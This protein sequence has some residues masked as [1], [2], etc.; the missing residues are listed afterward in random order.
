[1]VPFA[2]LPLGADARNLVARGWRG[3]VRTGPAKRQMM[4]EETTLPAPDAPGHFRDNWPYFW[5]NRANAWYTMALEKRLKPIGVDAP[6][7]RVIMSLYQH[8]HMSVSEIAEFSNVKLNTTTKVVQRLILDGLVAT[9]VRPSDARVTEV[10][11]T[12]RGE[13]LRAQAMVEV[14]RIR[15]ESFHHVSPAE[16]ETLN[17][18][19]RKICGDLG[20][21]I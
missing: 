6:R 2:G 3:C 1:M 17:A 10:R 7:W 19:L 20:R 18:I 8:D 15:E 12:P 9:R 13:Q 5:I 21:M 11:L 4:S 16:L 14:I